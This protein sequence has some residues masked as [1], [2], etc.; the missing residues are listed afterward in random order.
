M[1]DLF[2]KFLYT[3][4]GLVATSVERF[5]ESV[6]KLVEDKKISED[7][8]KKIVDDFVSN[9]EA[10]AEE[11][12]AKLRKIV[13]EVLHK[14]NLGKNDEV[15]DLEARIIALEEKIGAKSEEVVEEVKEETKPASKK[16]APA[17]KADA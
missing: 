2:K 15:S 4:V 13:E 12:E 16:R 11:F 3:S 14:F 8:G 5:Q 6:D 7:E 17:K 1:Q 9:T 10:K